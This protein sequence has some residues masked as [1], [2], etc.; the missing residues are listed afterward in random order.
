MTECIRVPVDAAPK[1]WGV[2]QF[3]RASLT[4]VYCESGQV[5]QDRGDG[6]QAGELYRLAMPQT[7]TSS[8]P[9]CTSP[10]SP[11]APK[12]STTS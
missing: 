3:E 4:V 1:P 11:S 5:A 9:R 8:K 10:T 12:N 7:P 6:A 2:W